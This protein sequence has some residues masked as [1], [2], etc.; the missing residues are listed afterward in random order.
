[1]ITSFIHQKVDTLFELIFTS[2]L[3]WGDLEDWYNIVTLLGICQ[4]LC[5]DPN[6]VEADDITQVLKS[7]WNWVV[8]QVLYLLNKWAFANTKQ[9]AYHTYV[10]N[11][12]NK[13]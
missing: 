1:M 8:S 2:K 4:I 11:P 10:D 13:M 5:F 9:K 12:Q 3:K 6:T 7:K